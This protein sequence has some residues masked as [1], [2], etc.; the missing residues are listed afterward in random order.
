ML[1]RDEV[2]RFLVT[3]PVGRFGTMFPSSRCRHDHCKISRMGFARSLQTHAPAEE[4]S[5]T[6]L[7]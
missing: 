4:P 7:G 2:E 5:V 3:V 1:S 6:L